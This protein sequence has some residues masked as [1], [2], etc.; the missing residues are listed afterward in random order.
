MDLEF[1]ANL[2]LYSGS[3]G[4]GYRETVSPGKK[5]SKLTSL[6][7]RPI[8]KIQNSK[9]KISNILKP[10]EQTCIVVIKPTHEPQADFVRLMNCVSKYL[11]F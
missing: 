9:L 6:F 5:N 10:W 2:L 11:H 7:V 1:E 3:C 8:R 4:Q